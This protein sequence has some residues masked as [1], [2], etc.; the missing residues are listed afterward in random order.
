MIVDEEQSITEK[1]KTYLQDENI[2][3]LTADNNREALNLLTQ[4]DKNTGETVLVKTHIPDT[5]QPAFFLFN[6]NTK[7][8]DQDLQNYL[9]HSFTKQEL[10]TFLKLNHK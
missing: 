5:K 6:S 10:L 9:P 1:I 4:D 7:T 8:Q 2:T 3:I